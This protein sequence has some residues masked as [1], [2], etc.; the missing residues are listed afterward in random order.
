MLTDTEDPYLPQINLFQTAERPVYFY[1]L[2]RLY[3][4]HQV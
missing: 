2:E 3:A 1:V 4:L